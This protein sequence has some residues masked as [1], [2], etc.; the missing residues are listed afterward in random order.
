MLEK[1]T[2]TVIDEFID[3]EKFRLDILK[4]LAKFTS[5]VISSFISFLS[6]VF[7]ALWKRAEPNG[8]FDAYNQNL[9]VQL[10]MLNTLEL[11][12]IP[13]ALLETIAY[14]LNRVGDYV[15]TTPGQSYEAN[16]TF[17]SRKSELS[18]KVVG[19]LSNI[20]KQHNYQHLSSLIK[21]IK[22]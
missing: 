7:D 13:P 4:T 15:G 17:D 6:A 21:R 18:D 11:E 20:A 16:E 9:I 8:A 14:N 10:D 3:D 2:D 1:S 5:P 19:E 22:E 12:H